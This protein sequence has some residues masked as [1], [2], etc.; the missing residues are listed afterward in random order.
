M[1]D[2]GL[3][4]LH[5]LHLENALFFFFHLLKGV[6]QLDAV[7]ITMSCHTAYT[8]YPGTQHTKDHLIIL[9]STLVGEPENRMENCVPFPRDVML[10]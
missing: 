8:K 4:A 3:L 6:L 7:G 10:G 2:M 5:H 1:E 9:I